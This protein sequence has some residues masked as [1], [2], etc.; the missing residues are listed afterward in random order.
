MAML[1]STCRVYAVNVTLTMDA[2]YGN[3]AMVQR[4]QNNLAALLNEINAAYGEKRNLNLRALPF[5]APTNVGESSPVD[6]LAT[7]WDMAHFYCD[8]EVVVRRCW[9][10]GDG[11]FF[12]RQIPFLTSAVLTFLELQPA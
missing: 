9:N 11:S 5:R 1:L 6:E 2:D 3:P 4:L 10:M 8:D 7:L 12:V